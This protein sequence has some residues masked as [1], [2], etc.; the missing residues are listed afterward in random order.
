M[1]MQ[2]FI[3][4][5]KRKFEWLGK[6]NGDPLVSCRYKGKLQLAPI[7]TADHLTFWLMTTPAKTVAH[8]DTFVSGQHT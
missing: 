5:P 7:G 4:S 3:A 8:A 1:L 2:L 6:Q